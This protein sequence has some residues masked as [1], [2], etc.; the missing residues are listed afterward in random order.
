MF[1]KA[2]DNPHSKELSVSE[3]QSCKISETFLECLTQSRL[4]KIATIFKVLKMCKTTVY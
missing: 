2:Q 3:C 1:C 4:S